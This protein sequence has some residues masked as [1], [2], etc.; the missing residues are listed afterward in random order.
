MASRL[1]LF[2]ID[3]TLLHGGRLWAE[4]F[5]ASLKE[6]FPGVP[7]Y[8]TSFGGKTDHQIYRE[9]LEMAGLKQDDFEHKMPDLKRTYIRLATEEVKRRAHEIKV[10][11]GVRDLLEKLR[12]RGDVLLAL[13]TGNLAEGA[14]AKLSSAGLW[15]YF[16]F[17]VFADDHWDRYQLPP[18]AVRR[19]KEVAGLH[20]EKKQIVIIGDTIHDVN[21]GKSIGVR[22]IAVGTGTLPNK[23]Q[24]LQE[25]PDYYFADLSETNSVVDAIFEEMS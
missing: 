1:V 6:H 22:S 7:L 2:D 14:K 24:L 21:C 23:R 5:Y 25:N 18:I 8:K 12:A 19:A 10:L 13:L 17:G 4:C 11:P 15:D 3:G 20:F 16:K 9:I